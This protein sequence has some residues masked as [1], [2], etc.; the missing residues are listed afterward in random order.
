MAR[1][2]ADAQERAVAAVDASAFLSKGWRASKE[3]RQ[4]REPSKELKGLGRGL[5]SLCGH[6]VDGGLLL[7]P[8]PLGR[9]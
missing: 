9:L 7:S 6:A 3:Q 5:G 2:L 4:A 1:L 8:L